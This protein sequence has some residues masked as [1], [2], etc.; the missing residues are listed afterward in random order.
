MAQLPRWET[1]RC[2][3]RG[4]P[5]GLADEEATRVERMNE[6]RCFLLNG[7]CSGKLVLRFGRCS[8]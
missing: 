7:Y 1:A 8:W 4:V 3:S 6:E 2:C 5:R